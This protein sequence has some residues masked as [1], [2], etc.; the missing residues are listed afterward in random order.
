MSNRAC[1]WMAAFCSYSVGSLNIPPTYSPWR[2]PLLN[3]RVLVAARHR[4]E[5]HTPILSGNVLDIDIYIASESGP[6]PWIWAI[7]SYTGAHLLLNVRILAR[8][9]NGREIDTPSFS[10]VIPDILLEEQPQSSPLGSQELFPSV[11]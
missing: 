1:E 8:K 3:V 7:F 5:I 2:A 4:T 10:D 6:P 9:R 11:H